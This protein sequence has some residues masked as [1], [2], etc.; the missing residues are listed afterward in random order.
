MAKARPCGRVFG[1]AGHG[2]PEAG[3]PL[4]LAGYCV[5]CSSGP[6]S[7]CGRSHWLGIHGF[8]L[9]WAPSVTNSSVAARSAAAFASHGFDDITAPVM[10]GTTADGRRPDCTQ[11]LELTAAPVL[12]GEAAQ[13][14]DGCRDGG[15]A[16][17]L[18][19]VTNGRATS[20]PPT[21]SA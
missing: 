7:M 3:E 2:P 20:S 12:R 19:G 17:V 5:G 14:T 6:N 18:A 16:S 13:Q 11:S 8:E 9:T 4:P 15:A 21:A 1:A 10:T